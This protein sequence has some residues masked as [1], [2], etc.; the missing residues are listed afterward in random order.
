MGIKV[1]F[2]F[3]ATLSRYDEEERLRKSP[4]TLSN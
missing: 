3:D 4:L 1:S 2:D